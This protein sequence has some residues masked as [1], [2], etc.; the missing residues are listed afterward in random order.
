[1]EL[2]VGQYTL[3][4]KNTELGVT[5]RITVKVAARGKA[6]ITQDLGRPTPKRR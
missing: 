4:L 1:L 5:R 3:T 6:V 2:P